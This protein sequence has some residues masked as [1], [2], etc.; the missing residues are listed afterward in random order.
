[1]KKILL[2]IDNML[3]GGANRVMA[4]LANHFS[5]QG[6]EVILINDR[7]YDKERPGYSINKQVKRYYLDIENHLFIVRTMNRLVKLRDIA[8]KEK[9]DVILS[10]MAGPNI[11]MLV[12]TT[13]LKIKRVVSVRND[14]QK[15]YGLGIKRGLVNLLFRMADGVVF[16]TQD[17]AAYF[18]KKIRAKSK[19]IFNPVNEKFYS[20]KWQHGG[21]NIVIVGR[22]QPQKNPMNALR[23]FTRIAKAI[24][25]YDLVYIGEGELKVELEAYAAQAGISERVHFLG[26][27]DD[28]DSILECSAMYVLCSDFEGMPN[29]LM[30]A[31]AVGIPVISTD[32]PCG[33]PRT[34]IKEELQ[35]VLVPC[36]RSDLLAEEMERLIKNR[37]LQLLMSEAERT[38]A[39]E[40]MPQIILTKW[41]EYLLNE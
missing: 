5:D 32:C 38:R 22:L 33:G 3:Y 19:V 8:K 37:D 30:E 21:K 15:E 34:L 36:G 20:K 40:F 28:I 13:G 29:A 25:E 18:S 35:G 16:Q 26:K 41:S 27:R 17:A 6:Y 23:A 14:P 11:R 9:T 24:P 39:K 7:P 2:Y 31:M 4:N 1:M 12:A 10:F